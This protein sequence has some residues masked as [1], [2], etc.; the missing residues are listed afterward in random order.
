[1][2]DLVGVAEQANKLPSMLSGGEQQR[3]AIARALA[4]DPPIIV[5]DEPTGNLDSKTSERVFQ[6]FE[7]LVASGKTIVM[8]EHWDS[9]AHYEKYLAWREETG[10]LSDFGALLEG[11]PMIRFFDVLDT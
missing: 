7:E 4:N 1:M 11:A 10:V 9:K 2:L 6:L 5:A 3:V 8:V